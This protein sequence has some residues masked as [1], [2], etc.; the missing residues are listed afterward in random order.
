MKADELL[1]EME[2][3]AKAMRN[4]NQALELDIQKTINALRSGAKVPAEAIEALDGILHDPKT[5]VWQRMPDLPDSD[6]GFQPNAEQIEFFRELIR[7]ATDGMEWGVPHTGQVYK[8]D[9]QVKTFTLIRETQKDTEDWHGKTKMI[10][11]LLG[12]RM[13]DNKASNRSFSATKDGWLI[14]VF[15]FS[16]ENQENPKTPGQNF[17]PG[18]R[19]QDA[20]ATL[21]NRGAFVRLGHV[22]GRELIKYVTTDFGYGKSTAAGS[23]LYEQRN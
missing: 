19:G 1:R 7:V 6:S 14:A 20:V 21:M 17:P 10:L 12:W 22:I 23:N 13:I 18:S 15:D 11:G 4:P 2:R 16:I 9:K 8:I 5:L 3:L